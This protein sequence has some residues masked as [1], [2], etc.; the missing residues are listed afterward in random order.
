MHGWTATMNATA[1]AIA[2]L[3]LVR[4][5]LLRD[6]RDSEVLFAVVCGSMALS[7]MQSWMGPAPEWMKW[8]VAIGGSATCN[9]FWLVSRALFRGEGGVRL[10]HVL[11]A[12]GVAMLI[13]IHRGSAL[14]AGVSPPAWN[15]VIDALLTLTSTSLLA[16]SFVEP[17]RGWSSHWTAAER[18]MRLCFVALYGASVLSTTLLGALADAFPELQPWHSAAVALCASAMIVFTHR[19]LQYRRRVPAGAS[20]RS[21]PLSGKEITVPDEED[22]RLMALLK[23]QLEVLQA[24]REPELRVIELAARLGTAEHRLSRLISQR[25]GEKNF[26]QLLNRY[27]IAHA[28]RLLAMRDGFETILQ[29]SFDSGFASPGPFN[30]AFKTL[31]GCTPT[32][33]RTRCLEEKLP[34][35]PVRTAGECLQP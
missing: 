1:V 11:F 22:A 20:H 35:H 27:R 34:E 28:C 3:S 16:L 21:R 4:L 26:N 25:L 7:L 23:H 5:L 13:A 14:D 29:V 18:R 32:A 33:Y 9:G 8:A 19:F 30:R 10:Q 24:Y 12:A 31:M 17:L 6:K 2:L 15:V